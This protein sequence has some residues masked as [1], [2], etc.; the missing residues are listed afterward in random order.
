MAAK[1]LPG[2]EYTIDDFH[3]FIIKESVGNESGAHFPIIGSPAAYAQ[4]EMCVLYPW[5]GI[6]D[7]AV[8]AGGNTTMHVAEGIYIDTKRL[9]DGQSFAAQGDE[10]WF[11]P[12]TKLYYDSE[13]A[14][15][16]LVGYVV[17]PVNSDGVM[18]FEKR[19]YVVEGEAT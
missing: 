15:L 3:N 11:D 6:I 7:D 18:R 13:D 1:N 19:R 12:V 17:F 14:G 8:A 9:A 2:S 10:V 16:Y 5:C 4:R